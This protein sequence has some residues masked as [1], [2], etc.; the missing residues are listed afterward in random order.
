MIGMINIKINIYK[1]KVKC[2]KK[3]YKIKQWYHN[4]II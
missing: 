1:K 4:N 3:M 2:K